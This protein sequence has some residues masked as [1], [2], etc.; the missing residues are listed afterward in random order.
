MKIAHGF[1]EELQHEAESTRAHLRSVPNDKLAWRPHPKSMS[2][3]A[4]ATHLA[5]IPTYGT[6]TLT[7][8]EFD[9]PADWKQEELG[10]SAELVAFHDKNLAELI[11]V[12]KN[13]DDAGFFAPWTLKFAGNVMFTMPRIQVM[14]A[15]VLSH[16]IHHRAQLGLYLRINDIAVPSAY[17]PTADSGMF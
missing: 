13:F 17:G 8:S 7:S 9:I 14:R 15:M 12:L 2:F 5:T 16:T 10:S 6:T 1:I 3:G 11:E 4:L